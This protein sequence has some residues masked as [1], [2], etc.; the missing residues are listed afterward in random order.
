M[1]PLQSWFDEY[2]E[3]HQN[4]TNKLLHWFCIPAIFYSII[5]LLASIPAGF[6]QQLLPEYL[7]PIAHF[8]TLLVFGGLIFYMLHSPSMAV[9]ILLYSIICLHFVHIFS[10]LSVPLWQSSLLIF[11]I[12]WIGQFY[13]HKVEGKKPSFFKDV[14]FLLIGPA[15]LLGFIYQK[16]G[17][18]Y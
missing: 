8:G 12:A 6:L 5:G 7:A 1:R 2:A 13:G 9:G 15:W 3:S 14:Q 16:L 11:T 18:P 10:H 17:I 4:P